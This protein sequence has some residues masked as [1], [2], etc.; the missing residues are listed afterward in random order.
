MPRPLQFDLDTQKWCF[1]KGIFDLWRGVLLSGPFLDASNTN[2]DNQRNEANGKASCGHQHV[3]A[4]HWLDGLVDIFGKTVVVFHGFFE[5]CMIHGNPQQ[6]S[7]FWCY[8]PVFL[9]LNNY[10]SCEDCGAEKQAFVTH[11]R[12][13]GKLF[14]SLGARRKCVFLFLL[15]ISMLLFLFHSWRIVEKQVVR[16]LIEQQPSRCAKSS[17]FYHPFGSKRQTQVHNGFYE[18]YIIS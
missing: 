17:D 18:G 2:V 7:L 4:N 8:K 14:L 16:N 5:P 13:I 3:L 15:L 12:H 9:V 1:V 6:P 10:W 11:S